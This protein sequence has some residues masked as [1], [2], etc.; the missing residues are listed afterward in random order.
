[1]NEIKLIGDYGSTEYRLGVGGDT[2]PYAINK[3]YNPRTVQSFGSF[4]QSNSK[5]ENRDS[6]LLV[7]SN[8]TDIQLRAKLLE[9]LFEGFAVSKVMLVKSAVASLYS[10]GRSSATVFECSHSNLE[11]VSVE[12]GY[13][14]QKNIFQSNNS[15]S[16]F[17]SIE[18]LRKID[19][20][21]NIGNQLPDETK[22]QISS[23]SKDA[24]CLINK[25]RTGCSAFSIDMI[26]TGR[27]LNIQNLYQSFSDS[28]ASQRF[29]PISTLP[30]E[31][32]PNAWFIGGSII[33]SI[34]ELNDLYVTKLVRL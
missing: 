2:E 11:L 15:I 6:F 26:F 29:I 25:Y 16:S 22:L 30:Q 34:P 32:Q 18:N 20:F 10:Y 19:N 9:E 13:L 33:A 4:L 21:N 27:G 8:K 23:L 28:A 24:D 14:D 3:L 5:I 17:L 12:D 31:H 7:E 1:M